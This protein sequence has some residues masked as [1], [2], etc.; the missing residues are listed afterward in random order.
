MEFHA[1]D[2][3]LVAG[4]LDGGYICSDAGGV[5]LQEVVDQHIGVMAWVSACIVVHSNPV[6]VEHGVRELVSQRIYRIAIEYEDLDDHG[7]LRSNALLS[8]LAGKRDV[9]G[10]NRK[11]CRDRGHALASASTLNRM[12][13]GEPKGVSRDR[14]MRIVAD[15]ETCPSI[16]YF[17]TLPRIEIYIT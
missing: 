12:E 16:N 14:H 3:R 17:G 4:R 7:E 15:P 6:S 13:L 11:R 5:L 10:E 1:L 9:M 8:L 2:R